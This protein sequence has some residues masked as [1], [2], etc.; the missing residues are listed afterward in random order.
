[1]SET[2]GGLGGDSFTMVKIAKDSV[3]VVKGSA[4][5]KLAWNSDGS[6]SVRYTLGVDSRNGAD[7]SLIRKMEPRWQQTRIRYFREPRE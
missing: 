6:V 3:F 7:I 2:V 1:M 5:I 4:S